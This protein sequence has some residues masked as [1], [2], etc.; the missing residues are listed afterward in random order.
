MKQIRSIVM[1]MTC[2]LLASCATPA[3]WEATDPHDFVAVTKSK[4]NEDELKAKGLS[5]RVDTE[6]DLVYVEKT[7][8]QKSKDYAIRAIT[9]PVTVAVDAVTTIAVVGAAVFVMEH[10][11]GRFLEAAQK[12][13]EEK[14]WEFLRETLDAIR[15]QE[16]EDPNHA[17]H[18]YAP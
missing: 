5:Y 1:L 4:V 6:R 10:S 14:E 11:D 7:R 3:L 13:R 8:L 2:C 18:A 16:M 17:L 15:T 12:E 9:T